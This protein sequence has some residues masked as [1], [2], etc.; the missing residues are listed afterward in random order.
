[1]RRPGDR[2]TRGVVLRYTSLKVGAVHG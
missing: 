2:Y 1:V